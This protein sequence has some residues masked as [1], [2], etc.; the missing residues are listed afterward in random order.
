VTKEEILA[1]KVGKELNIRVAEDVMGCKFIEDK[2]LVLCDT[3]L[4][5]TRLPRRW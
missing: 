4:R 1:M 5:T 3:I 2:I